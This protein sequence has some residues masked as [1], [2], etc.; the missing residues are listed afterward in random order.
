MSFSTLAGLKLIREQVADK[1]KWHQGGLFS[2][3]GSKCC[4]LG[5]IYCLNDREMTDRIKSSLWDTL[6]A[7]N[8]PT[9]ISEYNDTHSHAQVLELIDKSIATEEKVY[10]AQRNSI[11]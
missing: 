11:D 8:L 6:A 5:R 1:D 4:L 10:S 3:D 7:M 2:P 9:N